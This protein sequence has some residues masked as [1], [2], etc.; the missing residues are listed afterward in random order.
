[1]APGY[2]GPETLIWERLL[3]VLGDAIPLSWND[4]DIPEGWDMSQK[5][6]HIMAALQYVDTELSKRRRQVFHLRSV[7]GLPEEHCGTV[8]G[9]AKSTISS[10][11]TQAW[12]AMEENSVD[13]EAIEWFLKRET[14]GASRPKSKDQDGTERATI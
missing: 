12:T 5:E 11:L 8:L 4:E 2:R 7:L 10:T 9:V 3:T 13:I 6:K 1:M 14:S